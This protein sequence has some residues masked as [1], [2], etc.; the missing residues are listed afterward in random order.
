[1]AATLRRF[2]TARLLIARLLAGRFGASWHSHA[3]HAWGP[4]LPAALL[5]S[6]QRGRN[7][8]QNNYRPK[9][10]HIKGSSAEVD[11]QLGERRPNTSRWQTEN[12]AGCLNWAE[13]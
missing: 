8:K 11:R 13:F 2:S 5:R 7:Q 4:L 1:M 6:G 9:T 10:I 12:F 3:W